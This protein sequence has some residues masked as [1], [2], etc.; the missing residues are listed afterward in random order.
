VC[1]AQ[2]GAG[3]ERY[4]GGEEMTEILGVLGFLVGMILVLKDWTERDNR[5]KSLR[6]KLEK[7]TAEVEKLRL[8]ADIRKLGASND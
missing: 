4:T 1:I 7:A 6:E 2:G 8:E 3:L 5:E